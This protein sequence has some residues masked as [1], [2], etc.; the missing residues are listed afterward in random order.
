MVSVHWYLA[1]I[2]RPEYILLPPPPKP[3]PRPPP[4]TRHSR[5]LSGPQVSTSDGTEPVV[6]GEATT[7]VEEVPSVSEAT[8]TRNEDEDDPIEDADQFEEPVSVPE[9]ARSP[10]AVNG[11]VDE[12]M[13]TVTQRTHNCS[14]DSRDEDLSEEQEIQEH[15]GQV[16]GGGP[17]YRDDDNETVPDSEDEH[18]SRSS[19]LTTMDEDEVDRLQHTDEEAIAVDKEEVTREPSPAASSMSMDVDDRDDGEQNG[20]EHITATTTPSTR[21]SAEREASVDSGEQRKTTDDTVSTSSFYKRPLNPPPWEKSNE[22]DEDTRSSKS[23]KSSSEKREVEE[24]SILIEDADD[25]IDL[26]GDV[27]DDKTY[28]V[29]TR[30]RCSTMSYIFDFAEPTSLLWTPLVASTSKRGG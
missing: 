10:I 26:T 5:R 2:Y 25:T 27:L 15:L 24:E 17:G 13:I 1:I 21:T 4:S 3:T 30:Y 28:V 8:S 16:E 7:I 19:S 29:I 9:Q 22:K 11:D 23:F 20:G 12:D 14:I 18:A 6:N